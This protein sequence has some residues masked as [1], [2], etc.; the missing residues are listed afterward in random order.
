MAKR[1]DRRATKSSRAGPRQT[2]TRQLAHTLNKDE[3]EGKVD[4]CGGQVRCVGFWTL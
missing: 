2:R 4:F 1:L 3:Q